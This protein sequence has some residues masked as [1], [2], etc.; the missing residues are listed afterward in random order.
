M[1]RDVVQNDLS[2]KGL[3]DTNDVALKKAMEENDARMKEAIE[4]NDLYLKNALKENDDKIKT[5]LGQLEANDKEV[6]QAV[7]RELASVRD[8]VKRIGESVS[9]GPL[10][11]LAVTTR[12]VALEGRTDALET[13]TQHCKSELV[14]CQATIS[15]LHENLAGLKLSGDQAHS[16]A[17]AA[18]LQVAEVVRM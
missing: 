2:N 6:R 5:G 16:M 4:H 15:Q 18:A 14:V 10:T 11:E 1:I 7:N 13:K 3:L 17:Q 9:K 12:I 8:E